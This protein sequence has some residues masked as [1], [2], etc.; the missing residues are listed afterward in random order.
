MLV[1]IFEN[2]LDVSQDFC[3]LSLLV[4]CEFVMGKEGEEKV[5]WGRKREGEKDNDLKVSGRI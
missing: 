1:Q 5:G 4:D 3:S 2:H